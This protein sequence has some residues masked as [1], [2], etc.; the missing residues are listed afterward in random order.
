VAKR[1]REAQWAALA[2]ACPDA[3]SFEVPEDVQVMVEAATAIGDLKL[4]SAPNF[5]P[6]EVGW[7]G[8]SGW[9][10]GWVRR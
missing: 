9:T 5:I 10:A 8:G 3:A 1:E 4:R 7:V 6:E 2:A